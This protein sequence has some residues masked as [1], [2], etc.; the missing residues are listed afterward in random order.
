MSLNRLLH[1]FSFYCPGCLHVSWVANKMQHFLSL[2][3]QQITDDIIRKWNICSCLTGRL[4][5]AQ[6]H[7]WNIL[8]Y[9]AI[10]RPVL[11]EVM[12]LPWRPDRVLVQRTLRQPQASRSQRPDSKLPL[13]SAFIEGWHRRI[14]SHLA[15]IQRGWIHKLE[16]FTLVGE[17]NLQFTVYILS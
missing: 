13:F 14:R 7:P 1:I 16:A 11:M 17:G 3:H 15:S 12:E 9:E 5:N 8:M 6:N 10:R 4:R 2:C